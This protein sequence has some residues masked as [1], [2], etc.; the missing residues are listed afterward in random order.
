VPMNGGRVQPYAR[1]RQGT[2]LTLTPGG[3]VAQA[4][5]PPLLAP[6]V[7]LIAPAQTP[8]TPVIVG[9]SGR[10]V[11]ISPSPAVRPRPAATPAPVGTSG[12]TV[13][14]TN[15]RAGSAA[16]PRGI[17]NAWLVFN[18]RT[19]IANGKAEELTGEFTQIGTHS[20]FPVYTRNGDRGT[21]YFPSI[22][23][24]VVPFTPRSR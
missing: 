9:T 23:G 22:P 8:A 16:Q 19:W 20:G 3:F 21:I 24:L 11:A 13:T 2:G 15:A 7:D 4:P 14:V 17:N 18:G 5:Q 10:I 6:P 12:R 1:L